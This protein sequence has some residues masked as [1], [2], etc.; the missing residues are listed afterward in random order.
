MASAN[1]FEKEYDSSGEIN[2]VFETTVLPKCAGISSK[3]KY[4]QLWG[5]RR[6]V[7][8][9]CEI[10]CLYLFFMTLYS[11]YKS[12]ETKSL[13]VYSCIRKANNQKRGQRQ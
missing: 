10:Y 8:V 9:Q 3:D 5:Q 13:L 11:S 2:R 1:R 4:H 12:P 7:G 6:D